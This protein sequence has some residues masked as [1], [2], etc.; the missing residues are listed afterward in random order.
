MLLKRVLYGLICLGIFANVQLLWAQDSLSTAKTVPP[1]Y[2]LNIQPLDQTAGFL[3]RQKIPLE[4]SIRDSADLEKALQKTL[5]SLHER[6]YLAASLDTIFLDQTTYTAYLFV[7]ARY[8]WA[9]LKN[10][11]V[12]PAF[13]AAIGFKERLYAQHP[14]YYKEVVEVQEKLLRYLEN[15][16]YPFAQVYLDSVRL[17]ESAIAARLYYNKG[18]LITF[19]A[20][21][22]K[23][24]RN[25]QRANKGG[26]DVRITK[27]FMSSYLGIQEGKLYNER[28]VKKVQQRINALRYLNTYQSPTVIFKDK[29]AELNLFLAN[30]P[31]SKIDVL[32][33]F[34]PSRDPATG[35]Q[36]FDFTGN[37]DID[38]LN[39][40]GTGKRLQFKWQQLSLG[41]SD[42]LVAFK[43]PYLLKTPL[44]VDV[45]FKLYRRD[46]SF[47]DVIFDVGLQY[48][49]NGNSYVKAFWLNTTTNLIQ[50]NE[51]AVLTSRRLPAMLDLNNTA[52]GLEFYHNQLDYKFNPRRGFE[53]Q[54]TA[55]FALKQVRKNNSILELNDPQNP[56]F[57]Y[58]S[59]YDTIRLNTF[60]YRI[61][62][63]HFHFF[64][65]LPWSTIM[66][67]LRSGLILGEDIYDNEAYRIGGNKLLRGFDEES[68]FATWY[69]VLTL[70]WRFLFG[71]NSYAY[72][73]GDFTYLQKRTRGESYDDFPIGF[74]VGVALETKVGIFALSYAL[75]TERGNPILFNNSKVHFGYVYSF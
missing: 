73:F 15:H 64:Q 61:K 53:S 71:R 28:L 39:P 9:S 32:L 65:V 21:E 22:I 8:E 63:Q 48:L 49:F 69:N 38:L 40:F 75:G 58:E 44:G 47:I 23:G 25:A 72:A 34:L 36:R 3:K 33:G 50:V 18:P 17:G 54:L 52:F 26:K 62:L 6:A 12:N 27:G 35:Q 29:K 19:E 59:L 55:S 5:L 57:S 37:I 7:G 56:D 60:Q 51:Q 16:G 10:G 45:A 30:R 1:T 66:I 74:G 14:F 46:S 13:L 31:S 20:L 70:E 11:N 41:T 68:I 42:L 2:T 24:Q 4:Q 67:G 43:W